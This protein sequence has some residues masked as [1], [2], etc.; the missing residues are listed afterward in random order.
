METRKGRMQNRGDSF[1]LFLLLFWSCTKYEWYHHHHTTIPVSTFFFINGG[2]FTSLNLDL[3]RTLVFSRVPL[4]RRP[5]PNQ[6][7]YG[8]VVPWYHT[9]S[10]HTI[11]FVDRAKLGTVCVWWWGVTIQRFAKKEKLHIHYFCIN[12]SQTNPLPTVLSQHI[13]TP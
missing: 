2:V 10:Y 3:V 9:L 4:F 1:K 5:P 6:G 13:R 7:N 8:V 12:Q 11:L